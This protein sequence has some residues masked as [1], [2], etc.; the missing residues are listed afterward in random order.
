MDNKTK[1]AE[2]GVNYYEVDFADGY[3]IVIKGTVQPTVEEA[4]EFCKKEGVAVAVT[5]ITREEATN[6][7]DMSREDEWP[8]FNREVAA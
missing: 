1:S 8:V 7:Y 3:G 4:K 6:F 5:P 2:S